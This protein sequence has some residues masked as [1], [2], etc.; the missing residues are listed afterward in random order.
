[1]WNCGL[2]VRCE[3]AGRNYPRTSTG[4]VAI[5]ISIGLEFVLTNTINLTL[6]WKGNNI[7][8]GVS[9]D[10]RGV[11]CFPELIAQNKTNYIIL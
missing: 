8:E 1:M 5:T 11:V 7:A 9:R 2:H 4:K 6:S 10:L 3:F